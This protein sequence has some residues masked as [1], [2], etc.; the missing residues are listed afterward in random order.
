MFAVFFYLNVI[1]GDTLTNRT[2]TESCC[3]IGQYI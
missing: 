3:Q 1:F 2:R